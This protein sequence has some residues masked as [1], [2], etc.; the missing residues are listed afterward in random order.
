MRILRGDSRLQKRVGNDQIALLK[1]TSSYPAPVAGFANET[2]PDM[3]KRFKL[4][5]A[6]RSYD[7]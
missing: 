4:L 1:C 2:I 5:R 3:R 6:F 7:V